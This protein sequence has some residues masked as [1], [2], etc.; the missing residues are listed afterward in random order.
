[1]VVSGETRLAALIGAPARHSLSPAIHNA[2]FASTGVDWVFLAFEVGPGHAG[3]A[4]DA[5][6]VLPIEGLSV[7]MP[8]KTD[9]AHLVDDLTDEAH[10]LD[11][12]NC[13]VRDGQRLVGH[14]TDGMGFLASLV[15]GADGFEPR[16]RRCV[17][18]GAGGAAR[19]VIAAL[20]G[21][22][23]GEVIVTNRTPERAE[24]AAR[25]AGDV[26]RVG[27]VEDLVRD[28]SAADLVVHATSV[29]M[30]GQ[31]LALGPEA[32]AAIAAHGVV[33]DLIYSPRTTPLLA[34]AR[35]RGLT[36][37]G[38]L[39]MLVHQAAAAFTLWTGRPAPIEVMAQAAEAG[40]GASR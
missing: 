2:A 35:Q 8:H 28:L 9:V 39:G 5:M 11:A 6:R 30:D 34:A 37:V 22:G 10:R 38:G 16:G 1:M 17:V 15:E 18:V 19:A 27:R 7:T 3:A 36:T 13:V 24:V 23:A 21:A 32:V 31:G 25:L 12:V 14:N 20:A 33:V 4:L 26:G 29:G 40:L